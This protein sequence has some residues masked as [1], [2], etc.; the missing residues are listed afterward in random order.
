MA[1][2]AI[3][4][5]SDSNL[6]LIASTDDAAALA[7]RLTSMQPFTVDVFAEF[8]GKASLLPAVQNLLQA[9]HRANGWHESPAAEIAQTVCQAF[10]AQAR[11]E[12][13][14]RDEAA[15]EPASPDT[16]EEDAGG[17]QSQKHDPRWHA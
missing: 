6:A 14:L 17:Q 10:V 7:N 11:Q 5:R 13:E 16:S 1:S 8:P 15:E 12:Q 3:L 9:Q 2:L 4:H